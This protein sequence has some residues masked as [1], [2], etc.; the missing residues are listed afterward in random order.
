[1]PQ[2][3]VAH[4]QICLSPVVSLNL[5]C[6]V[7][8]LWKMSGDF[9]D[10]SDNDD[11]NDDDDDNDNDDSGP[12]DMHQRAL[13]RIVFRFITTK[14]CAHLVARIANLTGL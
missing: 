10:S 8:Q 5:A 11:D 13:H 9:R 1:M 7:D 6:Y 4:T 12:M 14:P 2:H 3:E